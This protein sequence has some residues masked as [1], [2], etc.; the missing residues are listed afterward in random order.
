MGLRNDSQMLQISAPV[1]P[2]NSG[3]PLLDQSGQIIGVIVAK[4]DVA[5]TM[6]ITGDVAQ[7]INFAIKSSSALNFLETN[8]VTVKVGTDTTANRRPTSQI[9]QNSSRY[10]SRASEFSLRRTGSTREP[11]VSWI[12]QAPYRAGLR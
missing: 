12:R 6:P 2:G 4:L 11:P 8:G 1:Q 3:G 10:S 7:N 9:S 5:K